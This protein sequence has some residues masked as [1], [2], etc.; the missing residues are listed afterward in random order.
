ME[1]YVNGKIK[2]VVTE[3][4]PLARGGDAISRLSTRT[5]RG[6]IIVTI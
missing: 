5:A 1:L 6:K 2:P 3:T 4:F